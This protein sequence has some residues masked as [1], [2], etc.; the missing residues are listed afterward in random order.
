MN[1]NLETVRFVTER[2]EQLQGLRIVSIGLSFAA[3]FGTYVLAGGPGGDWGLIAAI[4]AAFVAVAGG[5]I[6]CDRYYRA[7]FGRVMRSPAGEGNLWVPITVSVGTT[8]GGKLLHTSPA[9][10]AVAINAAWALWIGIRDWPFR[11]HHLLGAAG[12]GATV[13]ALLS[14][15]RP[16]RDMDAAIGFALLGVVYVL[17]GFLDHRLLTSVM[18]RRDFVRSEV[19]PTKQD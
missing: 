14:L 19:A 3:C 9:T 16:H 15:P 2:Y 4:A 5:M 1:P 7:R 6:L 17:I 13:A 12:C 18:R 11:A 10:I 8:I